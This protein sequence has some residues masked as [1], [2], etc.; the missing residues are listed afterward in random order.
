MGRTADG[1]VPFLGIIRLLTL[2]NSF[3]GTCELQLENVPKLLEPCM[4]IVPV[5]DKHVIGSSDETIVEPDLS[6][7]VQ[8]LCNKL[9]VFA[10]G[11]L[12]IEF[13]LIGPTLF[14]D[15]LKMPLVG[16]PKWIR[17][18]T[19]LK[20]VQVNAAGDL[21]GIPKTVME[22]LPRTIERLK[23]ARHKV[24]V[25]ELSRQPSSLV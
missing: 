2:A 9:D 5:P 18:Q 14:F 13:D 4:N 6:D 15:S 7:R 25:E 19:I 10:L 21:G 1:I 12:L 22:Q 23:L 11:N 24:W 20:Q 16:T 3:K 17:Y 8:T